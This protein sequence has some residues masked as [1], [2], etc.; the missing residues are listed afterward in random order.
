MSTFD[1]AIKQ[2]ERAANAMKLEPRVL[3]LLKIPERTVEVSLPLEYDD[4]TFEILKGYRVQHSSARGPYK[5]GLR[6]HPQ[7]DFDE[8]KSLALW[9]TIKCAVVG[10]PFGGGKGGITVDP[11]KLSEGELERLTR[12]LAR[13]MAPLW[14]PDRDVPAPDVNTNPKIMGWIADEYTKVVGKP[15]PAVI[16]GKTIEDGGIAGRDTATSDGGLMVLKKFVAPGA[17]IVV[18]GFGN[19]GSLF[20]KSAAAAGYKIVAVTDSRGGVAGDDLDLAALIKIKQET[21]RLGDGVT[22]AELLELP[23]DVLALAALEN[24]ITG[25]NAGRIKAKYILELANGPINADGQKILLE[26]GVVILPDVLSNAG[27]VTVSAF[28]W[29]TNKAGETWDREK[30]RVE[31]QK[32]MDAATDAMIAAAKEFGVDYRTAAYIVALRRIA[33][34]MK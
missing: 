29:Q 18:Q 11:K 6:Y 27:G 7:V 19:A 24:Q 22:N 14:G 34:A 25:E 13:K 33:E 23:C 17:R 26:R 10:I 20:A 16:T 1:S 2:L 3:E 4:G 8:V 31:L 9:M 21:G 15:T 30:V 32:V 28:E 5:G 12:E